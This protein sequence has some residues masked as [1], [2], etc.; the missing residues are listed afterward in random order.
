LRLD[1]SLK[2]AVDKGDYVEN[3]Q[4]YVPTAHQGLK[5]IV[6]LV[7]MELNETS[8]IDIVLANLLYK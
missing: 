2:L 7:M 4:I 1:K 3:T 6:E 5:N 8:E